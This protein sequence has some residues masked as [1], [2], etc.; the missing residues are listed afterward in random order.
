MS[1][2]YFDTAKIT[3]EATA[4]AVSTTGSSNI[5]TDEADLEGSLDGLGGNSS[6]DVSFE[7]RETGA[8]S[9]NQT[10]PITK[11]ATGVYTQTVTGLNSDTDYEFR[12]FA[13]G[14]DSGETATGGRLTFTTESP[15]RTSGVI[16]DFEDND[17]Q[18][19]GGDTANFSTQSTTVFEGS[20]ALETTLPSNDFAGITSVGGLDRYPNAGDTFQVRIR[21]DSTDSIKYVAW[22]AQSIAESPDAYQ[23]IVDANSNNFTIARQE[24]GY[25]EL[26]TTNYDPATNADEW[27][28]VEV[29]HGEGG[30]ITATLY[31]SN[32]SQ[33]NQLNAADATFTEGGVNFI[34]SSSNDDS[35]TTYWDLAE[36]TATTSGTGVIDDFEDN[37]ISEYQGS[38]TGFITQTGTVYEGSYA[39]SQNDSSADFTEMFSNSG[40]PRYPQSGDTFELRAYAD[41]SGSGDPEQQPQTLF[42]VQDADNLYMVGTTEGSTDGLRIWVKSGGSF[43]K[44]ASSSSSGVPIDEWM[45]W[46]I[47]WSSDGNITFT[48]Y[49]N[50]GNKVDSISATD[51]AYSGGGFGFRG[52]YNSYYD[53]A[54]IA[55]SG[56]TSATGTV[57]DFEDGDVAEYSGDT[58]SFDVTS[59][60]VQNGSLSLETTTAGN[61]SMTSTSGLD[62]Y[63]EAGDTFRV[64]WQPEEGDTSTDDRLFFASQ[65]TSVDNNYR[66]HL[67]PQQ[68]EFAFAKFE[69]G[70]QTRLAV[71]NQSYTDNTWYEVEVEWGANGSF[72]VTL[73]DD[74]G[75]QLN[76]LTP[77]DTTFSSGG[78]GFQH[79]D[80]DGN[81]ITSW[82]DYF[83][84]I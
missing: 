47:K 37:D 68:N 18:E 64:W 84:I 38:K 79:R 7:Y 41:S 63:P 78:V 23:V 55:E 52:S 45:K 17:I 15:G 30:S 6:V 13:K 22:C 76:Q 74:T 12:S 36:I 4:V 26:A 10:S 31:D 61:I 60:R 83:R 5:T 19:Y 72:T 56:D 35:A 71:S 53:I 43:N 77:T 67:Y 16:D 8:S 65:S 39:L 62:R 50:S 44:I 58:G 51:T 27:M 82:F 24:S 69:G 46:V 2:T 59:N 42:G 75:S 3:A 49:D 14:N 9:W 33:V 1:N 66:V 21:W 20:Y 81:G 54:E 48:V 70:S 40:L 34:E 28:R 80:A 73:F 25:N 32:D 29:E 11:S 57:D